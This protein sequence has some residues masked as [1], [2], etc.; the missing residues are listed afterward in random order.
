LPSVNA[1]LCRNV[2]MAREIGDAPYVSNCY[3]R[4]GND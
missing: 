4:I 1:S 2:Q 3:F